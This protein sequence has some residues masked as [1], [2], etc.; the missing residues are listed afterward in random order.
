MPHP[1]H[2]NICH[3]CQRN[4]SISEAILN[5]DLRNWDKRQNFVRKIVDALGCK[6]CCLFSQW[7]I[8]VMVA[9]VK[10]VRMTRGDE[11]LMEQRSDG[12]WL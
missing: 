1:H 4:V 9:I 7:A 11:T 3:N 5:D 6:S 12:H 10:C 8:V 2:N